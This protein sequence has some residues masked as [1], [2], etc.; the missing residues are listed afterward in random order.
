MRILGPGL[1]LQGGISAKRKN[2]TH[3][4]GNTED[5]QG[6]PMKPGHLGVV[7]VSRRNNTAAASALSHSAISSVSLLQVQHHLFLSVATLRTW[8]FLASLWSLSKI[9]G[10]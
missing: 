7:G 5:N 2:I 10:V 8:Q 4:P 1:Q 6:Q 9:V 3:F